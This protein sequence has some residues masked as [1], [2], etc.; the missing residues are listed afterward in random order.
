MKRYIILIIGLS[1]VYISSCQKLNIEKGTPKC[2]TS[3]IKDFDN[4]QNCMDSVN[5]KK[6]SFQGKIVYVFN[7]GICGADMTSEVV[8]YN[9]NS[10]GFLGGISG[11]TIINCED[12]SHAK[13][14]SV[15]W[16]KK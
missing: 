3:L 4:S 14:E 12:F 5:V 11:N 8:D 15:T 9:C 10:L 6:Y 1:I 13:F 16:E 2:I 7:P